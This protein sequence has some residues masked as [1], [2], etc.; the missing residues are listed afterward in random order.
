[1]DP[2]LGNSWFRVAHGK[3]G[4][5]IWGRDWDR[6]LPYHFLPRTFPCSPQNWPKLKRSRKAFG[7]HIRPVE[8]SLSTCPNHKKG[9]PALHLWL[10][11]L[12]PKTKQI[13][14][15]RRPFNN[16]KRISSSKHALISG[17]DYHQEGKKKKNSH[18]TWN[19]IVAV[20]SFLGGLLPSHLEP[21]SFSVGWF[22]SQKR[23]GS[24]WQGTG[25]LHLLG[26]GKAPLVDICPA[27]KSWKLYHQK[28]KGAWFGG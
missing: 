27:G 10:C 23:P 21:K 17:S 1:M 20:F 13:T 22:S 16:L 25:K 3:E 28:A 9:L 24:V 15:R 19:V 5:G 11:M 8:L 14:F 6:F 7:D 26:L 2:N 18:S 4:Q 12:C